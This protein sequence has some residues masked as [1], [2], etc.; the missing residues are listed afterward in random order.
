MCVG[1]T[2]PEENLVSGT[3]VQFSDLRLKDDIYVV[4]GGGA[5]SVRGRVTGLGPNRELTLNGIINFG[6]DDSFSFI[7]LEES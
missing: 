2:P 6:T 7:V 3:C 4:P 1:R 5:P